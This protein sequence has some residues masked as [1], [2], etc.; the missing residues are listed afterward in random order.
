MSEET[1]RLK[2]NS[3]VNIL[4]ANVAELSRI[5]EFRRKRKRANL[6]L[7]HDFEARLQSKRAAVVLSNLNI[8]ASA[9]VI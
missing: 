4:S 3:I 6:P 7:I 5:P 2:I 8:I 1:P 9:H